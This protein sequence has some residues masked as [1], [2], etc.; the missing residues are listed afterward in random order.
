MA[1][2]GL[3]FASGLLV[4]YTGTAGTTAAFSAEVNEVIITVSSVAYVRVGGTATKGAGSMVL[5]AGIPLRIKILPGSTVSA[6]QDSAGGNLCV[7]PIF[8]R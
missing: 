1:E 4:A 2:R 6:I 7:I 8:P 5:A 3:D